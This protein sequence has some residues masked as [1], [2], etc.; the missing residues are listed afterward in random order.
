M[1]DV[2][3]EMVIMPTNLADQHLN[4]AQKQHIARRTRRNAVST[5][6]DPQQD[7]LV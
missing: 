6:I 4:L 5:K 2:I 1:V 3:D 7:F